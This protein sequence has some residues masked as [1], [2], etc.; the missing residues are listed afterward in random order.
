MP[1]RSVEG[2]EDVE[3]IQCHAD[4]LVSFFPN[5]L[6]FLS[7]FSYQLV[8]SH[9]FKSFSRRQSG[10]TQEK[11]AHRLVYILVSERFVR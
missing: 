1:S 10:S 5:S 2:L 4:I 8:Q 11:K 3:D 9:T 7:L 6:T